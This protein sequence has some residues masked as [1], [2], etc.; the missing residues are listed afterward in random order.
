MIQNK[1]FLTFITL[2]GVALFVGLF[3]YLMNSI[4]TL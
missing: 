4:N 3:A 2:L 1:K